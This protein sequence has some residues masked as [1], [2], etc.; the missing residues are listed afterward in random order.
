MWSPTVLNCV[1]IL[2]TEPVLYDCGRTSGIGWSGWLKRWVAGGSDSLEAGGL[3][4]RLRPAPPIF[5]KGGTRGSVPGTGVSGVSGVFF[6][7]NAGT[8]QP[9]LT[10]PRR[11]GK[12]TPVEPGNPGRRRNPPRRHLVTLPVAAFGGRWRTISVA[13]KPLG[14]DQPLAL[15]LRGQSLA[16]TVAL[17][18]TV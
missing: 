4:H 2:I 8:L 10:P 15:N 17:N 7:P 12:N 9:G 13:Q 5:R 11:A 3:S 14:I 16:V 6:P 18:L 1:G